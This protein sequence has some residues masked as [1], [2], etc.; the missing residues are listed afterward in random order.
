[1]IILPKPLM[2]I[3]WDFCGDLRNRRTRRHK[4]VMLEFRA[5]EILLGRPLPPSLLTG[6]GR[7][8]GEPIK[9]FMQFTYEKSQYKATLREAATMGYPNPR[10]AYGGVTKFNLEW[11]V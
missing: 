6:M 7:K 4:F 1:M 11:N 2:R 10:R 5:W 9:R 3:V 8:L